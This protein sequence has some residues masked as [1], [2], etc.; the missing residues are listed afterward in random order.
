MDWLV[1][2]T[3]DC[4]QTRQQAIVQASS[5]TWAMVEFMVKYKGIILEVKEVQQ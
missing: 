5:Y 4:D 1:I 2:Y 3:I